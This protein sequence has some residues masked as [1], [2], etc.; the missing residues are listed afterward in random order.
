MKNSIYLIICTILIFGACKKN[1]IAADNGCISQ[2]TRHYVDAADSTAAANLLKQNNISVNNLVYYRTTFD[3]T[4]TS[5]TGVKN[6]NQQIFALQYFNGLPLF[7]SDIA[8]FFQNGNYQSTAGTRYNGINLN[9]IP[10]LTL[11]QLRK[12][13]LD[14]ATLNQGPISINLKD[15]CLV[16]EFGYYDVNALINN[17]TPNFVK[18]WSVTPKNSNYPI[19]IFRDDNGKTITYISGIVTIN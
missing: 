11:P 2:I 3:D 6:V 8:F 19:G 17:P 7:S 14:A 9:T 16:A 1:T 18:A 5:T 4:I 13:Y 10:N 12:L 15:S